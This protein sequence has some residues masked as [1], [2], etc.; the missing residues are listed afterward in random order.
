M[1][2]PQGIVFPFD[3]VPVVKEIEI[4]VIMAFSSTTS[5]K[6][7]NQGKSKKNHGLGAS[8]I[9]RGRKR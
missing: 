2:I 5:R 4:A 7:M 6:Q 9:K 3:E 8:G 1:E